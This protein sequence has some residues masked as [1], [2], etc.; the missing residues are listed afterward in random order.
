M[1][2]KDPFVRVCDFTQT[3]PKVFLE[4]KKKQPKKK[5]TCFNAF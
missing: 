5:M 4:K 1:G 3:Q 2:F